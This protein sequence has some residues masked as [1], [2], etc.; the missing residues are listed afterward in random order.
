MLYTMVLPIRSSYSLKEP[1]EGADG[2]AGAIGYWVACT[3]ESVF[4]HQGREREVFFML[5]ALCFDEQMS[6]YKRC[7]E[8]RGDMGWVWRVVCP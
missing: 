7:N 2:Q 8:G 4:S 3:G 5:H 1:G 6:R